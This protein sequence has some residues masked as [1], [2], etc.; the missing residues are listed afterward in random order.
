MKKNNREENRG[1]RRTDKD[2]KGRGQKFSELKL[3]WKMALEE[4]EEEEERG[5]SGA[6]SWVPTEKINKC[7]IGRQASVPGQ[8]VSV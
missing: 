6:V 5:K 4:E 7:W 3:E 1:D 8:C 2:T